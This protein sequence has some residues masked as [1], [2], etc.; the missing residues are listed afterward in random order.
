MNNISHNLKVIYILWL[1]QLKRHFR[2]KARVFSSIAQPVLF[3]IAFGFGFRS[4]Y[5]AAGQGDYLQFLAP[6][7]I[8]MSIVF[9]AMFSGIEVISDKQFGFLKETLIAPVSR[10]T[11]MFGRTLGGASVA[12]LQGIMVLAVTMLFGFWPHS[13]LMFLVAFFFMFL[14]AL[15]FTTIGTAFA[16]F[17]SDMHAFP[18]IINFVIMPVFFLSGALFPVHDLPKALSVVVKANVLSYGV[19]GLRGSLVG[20]FNFGIPTDLVVLVLSIAIFLALGSYL[21]NKMEV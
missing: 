1:R 19:D 2:S 5:A 8:T 17:F 14:I 3:L 9:S 7:I 10:L 20:N 15:L 6:G 13:V 18:I 21:F 16:S 12:I 11:I 4:V